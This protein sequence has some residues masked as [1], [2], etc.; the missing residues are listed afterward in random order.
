MCNFFNLSSHHS[1]SSLSSSHELRPDP[2][3]LLALHDSVSP[4]SRL[5]PPLSQRAGGAAEYDAAREAVLFIAPARFARLF[6][7]IENDHMALAVGR[8]SSSSS[9]NSDDKPSKDASLLELK[10]MS[11]GSKGVGFQMVLV[12]QLCSCAC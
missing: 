2:E 11:A 3:Q 9:S 8:G 7:A 12:P 4:F 10:R 6:S 5:L 1:L